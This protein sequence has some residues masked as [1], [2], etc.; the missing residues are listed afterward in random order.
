MQRLVQQEINVTNTRPSSQPYPPPSRGTISFANSIRDLYV[1]AEARGG[2]PADRGLLADYGFDARADNARFRPRSEEERSRN[3]LD[4]DCFVVNVNIA[5][6]LRLPVICL[7]DYLA[8]KCLR[9][10]ILRCK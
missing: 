2:R 10:A 3:G 7:L 5:L 6:S 8:F 1:H 9:N 4:P